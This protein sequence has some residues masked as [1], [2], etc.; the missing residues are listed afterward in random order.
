MVRLLTQE[1][2]PVTVAANKVNIDVGD[3]RDREEVDHEVL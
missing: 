1:G 3:W 2:I